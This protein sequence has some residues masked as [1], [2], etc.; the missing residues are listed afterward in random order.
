MKALLEKP[1]FRDSNLVGARFLG[2]D[3]QLH[4]F[5][6]IDLMGG[7]FKNGNCRG[8]D[9]SQ[10]N[11]SS[12]K[13]KNV[14]L[15]QAKFTEAHLEAGKIENSN[16]RGADFS[17]ANLFNAE[18]E[19]VNLAQAK[20]TGAHLG[21]VTFENINFE[22]TIFTGADLTDARYRQC[23]FKGAILIGVKG[24]P[25]EM[26]KK[27]KE[28]G[29]IVSCEQL[30]EAWQKGE[31]SHST[32]TL[33]KA[34]EPLSGK[35]ET[36]TALFRQTSTLL[37]SPEEYLNQHIAAVDLAFGNAIGLPNELIA[38]TRSFLPKEEVKNWVNLFQ[39]GQKPLLPAGSHKTLNEAEGKA[40]LRQSFVEQYYVS[41]NQGNVAHSVE[42]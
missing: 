16:C 12:A 36:E 3:C 40:A 10:A 26:L 22:G 9:F 8:A 29:A 27:A 1:S 17:Q 39:A 7:R 23:S 33:A 6:G 42:K 30:A 28:E 19:N 13:F 15:A 2:A 18:F 31:I 24:M 37:R 38:Y 41:L 34:L 20:F 21:G 25:P 5:S 14:S 35:D 32:A 11:L 4:D